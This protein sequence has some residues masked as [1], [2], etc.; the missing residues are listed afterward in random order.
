MHQH[1]LIEPS[2]SLTHSS[3]TEEYG[4]ILHVLTLIG[5]FQRRFRM[6]KAGVISSLSCGCVCFLKAKR[7]SRGVR[8]RVI[9]AGDLQ[10]L[11]I[12]Y[13]RPRCHVRKL[14]IL[15]IVLLKF[16]WLCA[17]REMSLHA[18]AAYS[19]CALYI[20]GWGWCTYINAYADDVHL[21]RPFYFVRDLPADTQ[22]M[23]FINVNSQK[24]FVN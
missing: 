19:K 7:L 2:L 10:T 20:N 4:Y 8:D 18:A 17:A 9:T 23:H 15:I 6:L 12:Y 13:T 1:F 21:N 5:L 11:C 24:C 16:F 22:K 14:F 3:G